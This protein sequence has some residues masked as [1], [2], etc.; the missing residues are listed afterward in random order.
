M[1]FPIRLQTSKIEFND[2]ISTVT[3][4]SCGTIGNMINNSHNES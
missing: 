1:K 3:R 4:E 2:P